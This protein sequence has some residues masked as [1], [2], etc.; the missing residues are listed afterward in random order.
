MATAASAPAWLRLLAVECLH[1]YMSYKGFASRLQRVFI[2][3]RG[4]GED[5]NVLTTLTS[6]LQNVLARYLEPNDPAAA[7]AAAAKAAEKKSVFSSSTK[8]PPPSAAA[9]LPNSRQVSALNVKADADAANVVGEELVTV[10]EASSV[11]LPDGAHKPR[12]LDARDQPLPPAPDPGLEEA[13][14]ELALLCTTRLIQAIGELC[15]VAPLAGLLD[16]DALAGRNLGTGGGVRKAQPKLNARQ[17]EANSAD[18]LDMMEN[19]WRLLLATLRMLLR[20]VRAPAL[21]VHVL[22]AAAVLLETC[23]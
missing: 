8:P 16:A 7:A 15:G 22:R 19:I 5:V 9:L 20:S 6:A 2:I 23:V 1:E 10:V 13:Q 17:H 4:E 21:L 14:L 18:C 3:C 11:L 12:L